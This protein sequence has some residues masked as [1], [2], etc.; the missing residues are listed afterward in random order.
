LHLEAALKMKTAN[1]SQQG[2][3]DFAEEVEMARDLHNSEME[4]ILADRP[5]DEQ[6]IEDQLRQTAFP[7]V[8]QVDVFGMEDTPADEESLEVAVP[9]MPPM[10]ALVD[11]DKVEVI[12]DD[13]Y[14]RIPKETFCQLAIELIKPDVAASPQPE[15]VIEAVRWLVRSGQGAVQYT[16]MAVKPE[17]RCAQYLTQDRN[18][19]CFEFADM[20]ASA[21]PA[22]IHVYHIGRVAVCKQAWTNGSTY[23]RTRG[24]Q[25]QTSK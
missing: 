11:R 1:M 4:L 5:Q 12:V 18:F 22:L 10:L 16:P 17:D 7:K 23:D 13:V 2:G 20:D 24:T 25:F 15:H 21:Y 8:A 14:Q 19:I 9:E 3:A 6:E